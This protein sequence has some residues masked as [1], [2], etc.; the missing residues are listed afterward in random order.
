MLGGKACL[1]AMQIVLKLQNNG[2][3]FV[4]ILILSALS[5]SG[6]HFVSESFFMT[7][8]PFTFS[9]VISDNLVWY[10]EKIPFV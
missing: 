5:F 1:L 4:V 3:I 10:V 6:S 9:C 7:E 2:L 8:M